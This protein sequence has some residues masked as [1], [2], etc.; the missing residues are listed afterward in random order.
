MNALTT[1]FLLHFAWRLWNIGER[2]NA[3]AVA[4]VSAAAAAIAGTCDF[5]RIPGDDEHHTIF[6]ILALTT[7]ASQMVVYYFGYCALQTAMT[8]LQLVEHQGPRS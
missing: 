8:E 3:I 6:Y 4:A 7:W 1:L 5:Y 2:G